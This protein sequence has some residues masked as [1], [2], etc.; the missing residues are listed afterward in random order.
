[1]LIVDSVVK[2]GNPYDCLS[3]RSMKISTNNVYL[4]RGVGQSTW[5]PSVVWD[6][7][8]LYTSKEV[9]MCVVRVSLLCHAPYVKCVTKGWN[10]E[11]ILNE[12]FKQI[13]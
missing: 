9:L 1:M 6:Q 2:H 13:R 8:Y 11:S 7:S 10:T 3:F 12:V 4:T 5:E